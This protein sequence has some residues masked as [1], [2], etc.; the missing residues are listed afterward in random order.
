MCV[1]VWEGEKNVDQCIC[2][3]RHKATYQIEEEGTEKIGKEEEG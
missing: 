1:C 3:A 2:F